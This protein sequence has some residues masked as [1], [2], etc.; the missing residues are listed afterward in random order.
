MMILVCSW[1]KLPAQNEVKNISIVLLPFQPEF[2]LSDAEHDIMTQTRR[3][4][5]EYR[6]YFRRVLDLKIQAELE[7]LGPCHSMLQDTTANGKEWL[8][9]FYERAAYTYADP[10]GPRIAKKNEL[11]EKENK[12]KLMNDPHAAPATITTRG[13]SKFMQVE[14]RD[15]S[16]LSSLMSLHSANLLVSINQ[17]EIK[18]NYN[19]CIDIANKIYRREL[20]IHYSILQ[21]NGKQVRGNFVMEFFPSNSNRDSDIAERSFPLIATELRKQVEELLSH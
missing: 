8:E 5:D 6:Q 11:K 9:K 21:P 13:D 17:F 20:L 3:T 19:S 7:G 1:Y 2:Y 10:V 4:P 18:T 15:T 16:F 12:F 14:V